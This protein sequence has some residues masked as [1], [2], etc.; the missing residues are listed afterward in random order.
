MHCYDPNE[1]LMNKLYD[2]MEAYI[3]GDTIKGD[4]KMA[5]AK[6]LFSKT[7]H[8]PF[9]ACGEIRDQID[10]W[11]QKGDDM[12]ARSDWPQISEKIYAD[13][14]AMIDKDI[15]EEFRLWGLGAWE[16]SGMFAGKIEK[17]FLD[18]LPAK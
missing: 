17:I 10:Q 16:W 11:M 1:D 18:N 14:K 5:E 4:A 15:S 3:S 13:N 12:I 8:G 7:M 6:P 2:S 9:T